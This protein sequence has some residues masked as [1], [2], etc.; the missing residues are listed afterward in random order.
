M[1]PAHVRQGTLGM[2]ASGNQF[3]GNGYGDLFRRNRSNIQSHGSMDALEQFWGQP[4][5]RQLAEDRNSFALGTNHSN[6]PGGRLH[7]PA[8]H[9]HIV[10]MPTSD[11]YNV[12]RL[13]WSESGHGLVKIL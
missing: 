13:I 8:Q 7:C 3:G 5:L 10:A 9:P 4:F 11:N 2:A 1:K 12:G 6:V